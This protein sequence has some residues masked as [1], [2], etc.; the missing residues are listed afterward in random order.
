[1]RK[2]HT[3]RNLVILA[4]IIA[5]AVAAVGLP[6]LLQQAPPPSTFTMVVH[7]YDPAKGTPQTLYNLTQAEL[8]NG[9]TVVVSGG[10][11]PAQTQFASGG[12]I[13]FTQLPAG[14][15][16]ITVSSPGYNSNTVPYSLGPNCVDRTPDGEC[17]PLVPMTKAS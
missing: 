9:A 3:A 16:Q 2:N 1:M 12:I 7:V 17:H 4:V 13:P 10:N 15:Y 5:I 6:S 14:A 11:Q 8:V